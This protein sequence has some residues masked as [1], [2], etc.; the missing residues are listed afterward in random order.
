MMSR[1]LVKLSLAA[2]LC[3]LAAYW[4]PRKTDSS[5][6]D[7]RPTSANG[8]GSADDSKMT[9]RF[10]EIEAQRNHLDQTIWSNELLALRHEEVFVR[11]WDQLRTQEDKFLVLE[12]FGFGE[13]R[14]GESQ[15]PE[16]IEHS[17]RLARHIGA[18]RLL[19]ANEWGPTLRKLKEQG[20]EIEQSEWRHP[21]FE[22]S[23]SVAASIITMTLNAVNRKN[24]ERLALR[25]NLRIQWQENSEVP[26]FPKVIE[27]TEI[28]LI[29]RKGNPAFATA[30]VQDITP[31]KENAR[32]TDPLLIVYDLDRDGLSEIILAGRNL[33]FWNL[34]HGQFERSPLRQY[35]PEP[36]LTGVIAD[37]DRDANADFL[38]AD[39]FGLLLFSGDLK[40]QFLRPGKR[41]G[42][43]AGQLLNPFVM[44]V[45]DIDRDD[46]LDV[47]LAQY[48]VPYLEGQM[49][50]PYYDA[51]DGFPS[52]LLVNDGQGNF[53]DQTEAA[54]LS[55]KRFR[56]TYSSSF[57]DLDN[58]NDLDLVVVSD[59]AGVDIYFNDG[60]GRFTDVTSKTVDEPHS[61]GMAHTFGDYDGDGKLDFFVIGMNSFVAQ[62]LEFMN[63]G[64]PEFSNYQEMRSRMAYGNR[65]YF[66]RD[67]RFQ[68]TA[69]SEQAARS[70]WSWGTTS[71][72]FDND[73][74]VDV[75]ITN[76]HKSRETA[77]DYETQF[78]RHDIYAATSEHDPALDLY[79]RSVGTKLYGAGQSYGGYDKNRLFLNRSG[80]QFLE[81]G[82]LMR[83]ALELDS[84]NVVS[85]DL[86]GDGKMDLLVTTF[87]VWPRAKQGL[88]LFQNDWPESGNWVGFRLRELGSGCS[89]IGAKVILESSHG[90]QI[91]YLVAGD[92]YRSQHSSTVH[93]GI[94]RETKVNRVEI[95]WPNG[96]STRIIDP[97]INRYHEVG[98]SAVK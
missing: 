77:R 16:D 43:K 47:W 36:I 45:G 71:A 6:D 21:Q 2:L 62:R 54:G 38:C 8:P 58:D 65:M 82:H 34:G 91:R 22:V 75:Y 93:F 4:F 63:L 42:F 49:P 24:Q 29:S 94:G 56:R 59:F 20:Y 74:D 92:S 81:V 27:A 25:G 51:N 31:P 41:I 39:H 46:D 95:R 5:P 98:E 35:A 18:D 19:S 7:S 11:L 33:V 70:G 30:L 23:N 78:W 12:N 9:K 57:V 55:A 66:G 26:P 10:L 61:F 67:G 14:F 40:G 72:D 86:D 79:F 68:Q 53:R 83:V 48:K 87:E 88:Y 15:A 97:A 37:F 1:T 3:G 69:L 80:K 96:R 32:S 44:T 60:Q 52:F 13:L 73:G 90:R 17:L 50:T 85:E 76:G 64:P 89:P 84:R 28:Q